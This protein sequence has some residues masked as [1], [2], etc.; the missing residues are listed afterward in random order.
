MLIWHLANAADCQANQ[1]LSLI[2][3]VL[4][5]QWSR[6]GSIVLLT[7]ISL[8]WPPTYLCPPQ[9]AANCQKPFFTS[10]SRAKKSIEFSPRLRKLLR[11]Y[12]CF[13]WKYTKSIW[14]H[15]EVF[16]LFLEAKKVKL[17]LYKKKKESN[18]RKSVY[19]ANSGLT[20]TFFCGF[21]IL[22]R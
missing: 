8:T 12:A 17:L 7:S 6:D 4:T 18:G 1:G 9:P 21:K 19:R 20:L 14:L 10:L 16:L 22:Q 15:L 5:F 2:S 3:L 11:I 13:Q